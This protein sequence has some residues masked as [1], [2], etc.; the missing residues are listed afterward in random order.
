MVLPSLSVMLGTGFIL[1]KLLCVS[2]R[3]AGLR[4]SQKT[5]D[6]PGAAPLN[7]PALW[8]SGN[9]GSHG[10]GPGRGYGGRDGDG[11]EGGEGDLY[12]VGEDAKQDTGSPGRG[13]GGGGGGSG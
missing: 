2:D 11:H 10:S 8:P 12:Y 1:V 7:S 4:R 9:Y 3:A 5:E 6:A 13:G